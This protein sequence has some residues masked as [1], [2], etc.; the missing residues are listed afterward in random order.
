MRK[1]F[2]IIAATFLPSLLLAQT[3]YYKLVRID[4]NGAIVTNVSGGQFVSFTKNQRACYE[5]DYEGYTVGNGRLEHD[6]PENGWDTYYGTSYWGGETTFLFNKDKSRLKVRT[7]KGDIYEYN[8]ATP[9]KGTTT[10]SL[11]RK[12][13]DDSSQQGTNSISPF[14]PQ[15]IPDYNTGGNN[16]GST[17][18]KGRIQRQEPVKHECPLCHGEKW[19]VHNSY[20]PLYG[21]ADYKVRCDRCGREFMKSTGH[22]HILCTQCHGLGYYVVK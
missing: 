8:I 18:Q 12:A 3:I 15:V 19:I 17:P 7:A 1:L 5:S 21:Q 22:Q 16:G 4:R 6:D 20:A 10:C 13:S 11:I 14:L 9:P 2:L